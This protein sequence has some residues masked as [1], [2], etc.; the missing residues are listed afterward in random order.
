MAAVFT[1]I[2]F[3]ICYWIPLT[4]VVEGFLSPILVGFESP[5]L[6]GF[7]SPDFGWGIV[8]LVDC[9]SIF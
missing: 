6:V 5:A 1:A 9:F 2:V 3:L 7:E 8:S 4:N